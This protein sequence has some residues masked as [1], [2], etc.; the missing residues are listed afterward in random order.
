MPAPPLS[1]TLGGTLQRHADGWHWSD[2]TP[3]TRVR[4]MLLSHVAPN[5]RC[6]RHGSITCVEIP[7]RW[8]QDA[9]YWPGGRIDTDAAAAIDS[10]IRECGKREPIFL[11]GLA[12]ALD[13][14]RLTGDGYIVDV[15]QWDAV[16]REPVG[17]WWDKSDEDAIL[18]RARSL[19]YEG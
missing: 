1:T 17:V 5:F 10:L 11:E 7:A 12:E 18:A 4:H 15:A 13:D 19:G 6:G 8:R 14:H 2:G 9:R 16:M 3:E